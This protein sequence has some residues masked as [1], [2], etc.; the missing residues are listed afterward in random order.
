MPGILT[1]SQELNDP[2]FHFTYY[3][4]FLKKFLFFKELLL[5]FKFIKIVVMTITLP[6]TN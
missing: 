6:T 3:K 1:F 2:F 4:P 5:N